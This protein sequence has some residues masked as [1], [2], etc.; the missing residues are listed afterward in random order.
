MA[1]FE[2]NAEKLLCAADLFQ[3]A[4]MAFEYPSEELAEGV[5]DGSLADDAFSCLVGMGCRQDEAKSLCEPLKALAE[6]AGSHKVL[7]NMRTEHSRLFAN[8]SRP[9]VW[10]YETMYCLRPEE[11]SDKPALFV[12]PTCLHVEN[13]MRR[14]GVKVS[15]TNKQPSDYLPTELF[16]LSYLCNLAAHEVMAVGVDERVA[17]EDGSDVNVAIDEKAYEQLSDFKHRH[18]DRW[19][20]RFMEDVASKTKLEEYRLLAGVVPVGLRMIEDII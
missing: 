9:V 1:S 5:S 16:F 15:E 4:G 20:V 14:A 13:T 3:I 8:T 17:V 11:M 2:G 18:I 12:S 7:V 19:A 10:I 6:N